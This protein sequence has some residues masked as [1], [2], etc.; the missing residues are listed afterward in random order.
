MS[1]VK[2]YMME[3]VDNASEN[4]SLKRVIADGAYDNKENFQYL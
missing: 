2:K 3:L 1:Q 4:N